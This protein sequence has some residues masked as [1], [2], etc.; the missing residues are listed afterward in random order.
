[1]HSML[2]GSPS[3]YGP[4]SHSVRQDLGERVQQFFSWKPSPLKKKK[5]EKIKKTQNLKPKVNSQQRSFP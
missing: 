4:S 2:S 5:K 3:K 1:M